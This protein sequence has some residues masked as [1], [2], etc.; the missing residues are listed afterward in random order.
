MLIDWSIIIPVRNGEMHI[1]RCLESLTK[2]E[3]DGKFEVIVVDNGST[4]ATGSIVR[5]YLPRL[6]IEILQRPKL[7]VGAVRNAGAEKAQGR[8]LAFLDADC[9]V[10][11][12]WLST[13]NRILNQHREAVIGAQYALPPEAGWP[14]R[15]WTRY[16]L[17]HKQGKT[18]YVPGGDLLIDAQL[19][20]RIGG[21]DPALR[22]NEDSQFCSRA[23][24]SGIPVLTF[25]E[26]AVVHFGA[27]KDL[28]HFARRQFWHGSNVLN[29]AGLK[30]NIRAIGLAAFTLTCVLSLFLF[31]VTLQLP[32]ILC[33]GLALLLAPVG[34]ALLSARRRWI[35]RDL[36]SL[37]VLLLTYALVRALVL[38]VA[39][40]RAV[41]P[42]RTS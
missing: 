37:F 27:E 30:G 1:G 38:P 5:S 33:S 21:F 13:A 3:F 15:V 25:K 22:S 34:L 11:P 12:S 4:D 40:A 41:S 17:D 7:H 14:S 18:S 29:A 8:S 24:A 42:A 36:P 6:K 10:A 39:I 23:K 28:R 19:F 9:A 2:L 31:G 20:R 32:A 35:W 26:L 16:F